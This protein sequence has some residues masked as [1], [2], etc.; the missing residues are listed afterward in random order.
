M[1]NF[2]EKADLPAKEVKI[3]RTLVEEN[4]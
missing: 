1:P 4:M 3:L 2:R